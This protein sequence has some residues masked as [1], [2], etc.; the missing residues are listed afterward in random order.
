MTHVDNAL[1]KGKYRKSSSRLKDWN[2]STPGFYF[3]TICTKE[4]H[5]IF[6]EIVEIEDAPGADICLSDAGKVVEECWKAI[7]NQYS[8]VSLGEHQ[9]MPHHFHGLIFIEE[10]KNILL[11]VIINQFKGACTRAM[12]ERGYEDFAWQARFYDHVVRNEKDLER[13]ERYIQENPAAWLFGEDEE[14]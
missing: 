3:V 6:G 9:V 2:Y 4:K 11:G 12:R 8:H 7:P 10:E 14:Q 5:R 1:F 13:I